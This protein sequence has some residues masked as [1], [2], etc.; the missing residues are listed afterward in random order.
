MPVG[1][2]LN[3]T[4]KYSINGV[5]N[6]AGSCND[7]GRYSRSTVTGAYSFPM[8]TFGSQHNEPSF[9]HL[10]VGKL[11]AGT[12][13]LSWLGAPNVQV[14]TRTNL[15]SGWWVSYPETIGAVWSAGINSPNGL[16]GV[17]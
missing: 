12:V 7:R 8:D 6:E 1:S 16:I 5:D 10:A 14:R 3:T 13:A 15:T 11:S 9:G 2:T 17:A 4:Y